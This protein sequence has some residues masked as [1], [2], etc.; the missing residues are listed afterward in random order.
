VYVQVVDSEVELN[1][2]EVCGKFSSVMDVRVG[3]A[4][5]LASLVSPS[6][7]KC[8]STVKVNFMNTNCIGSLFF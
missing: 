7:F 6:D 4:A 1:E 5:G 3:A 8:G 2:G